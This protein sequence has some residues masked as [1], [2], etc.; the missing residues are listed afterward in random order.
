MN[1]LVIN[2]G[3]GKLGGK[4]GV[5]TA[6]DFLNL[7]ISIVVHK[8]NE[9]FTKLSTRFC[10]AVKDNFPRIHRLYYYNYFI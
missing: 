7:G 6:D 10:T 3:R 9:L 5:S 2:R 8:A 4:V 1:K